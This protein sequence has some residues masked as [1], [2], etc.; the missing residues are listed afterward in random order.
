LTC[1]GAEKRYK[2]LYYI[3]YSVYSVVAVPEL[4]FCETRTVEKQG[5]VY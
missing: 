1:V 5:V 4:S 3:W 2:P